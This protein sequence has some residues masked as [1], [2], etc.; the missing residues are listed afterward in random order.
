MKDNPS[1]I[2]RL[3]KIAI[4]SL[5]LGREMARDRANRAADSLRDTRA[6]RLFTDTQQR[7]N[8]AFG[9]PAAPEKTAKTKANSSKRPRH[10]KH[11]PG[12]RQYSAKAARL[13][14]H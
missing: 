9:R 1:I 6:G 2:A 10:G 4:T 11:H 12:A 8:Q 3:K 14:P 7:L 13:T 5:D